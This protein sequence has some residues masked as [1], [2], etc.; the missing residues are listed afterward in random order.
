MTHC[1]TFFDLLKSTPI[2]K[3]DVINRLKKQHAES[4]K[5]NGAWNE[6]AVIAVAENYLTSIAEMNKRVASMPQFNP[7]ST[8]K[9]HTDYL[10]AQINEHLN[11]RAN[12]TG[13]IILKN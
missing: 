10:T 9:I 3:E 6:A 13:F 12:S 4:F 5:E 2:T 11:Q 8:T 7:L 1:P